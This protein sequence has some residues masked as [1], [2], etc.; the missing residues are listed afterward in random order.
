M[1]SGAG[2]PPSINIVFLI[3]LIDESIALP[4][5]ERFVR[6]VRPADVAPI[7]QLKFDNAAAAKYQFATESNL[8]YAVIA[9]DI[10]ASKHIDRMS[11]NNG[12]SKFLKNVD[13]RTA[14]GERIKARMA[15]VRTEQSTNVTTLVSIKPVYKREGLL[16]LVGTIG[17]Y[18]LIT[19]VLTIALYFMFIYRSGSEEE[20]TKNKVEKGGAAKAEGPKEKNVHR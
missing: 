8:R 12:K 4:M 17:G 15:K 1:W 20:S 6:E 9:R 18:W 14:M 5:H 3:S 19:V 7:R 2:P 16:V 11:F 10:D 13:D